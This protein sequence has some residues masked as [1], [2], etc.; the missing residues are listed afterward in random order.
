MAYA[1]ATTKRDQ[2]LAQLH[3]NLVAIATPTYG[4]NVKRVFTYDA[5]RLVLGGETPA[6]AVIPITDTRVRA[7]AC[8]SDEYRMNIQ[9]V[10]VLRVDPSASAWKSKIQLLAGDIQQVIANDRQL[11]SKAIYI[12]VDEVDIS[13]AEVSGNR[14][15]AVCAVAATIVYRVGVLDVTT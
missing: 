13:D 7:L 4:N 1:N 3:A 12:E 5:Q 10:G 14:V 6:I 8:S 15:L 11:T 9:I 2:V